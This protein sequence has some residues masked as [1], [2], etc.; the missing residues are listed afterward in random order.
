MGEDSESNN[1]IGAFVPFLPARSRG[2]I[3]RE[4]RLSTRN[5]PM[6]ESL[7]ACVFLLLY[8]IAYLAAGFLGIAAVE[9]A[10]VAIFR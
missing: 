6:K 3:R 4:R 1:P 2:L 5:L 8:A 9:R 10:W 7:S